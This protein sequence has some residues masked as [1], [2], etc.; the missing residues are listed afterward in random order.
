M[1][2]LKNVFFAC[3]KEYMC[4]FCYV[5]FLGVLESCEFNKKNSFKSE[6]SITEYHSFFF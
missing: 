2:Y 5:I 6:V 4:F 3:E 1:F